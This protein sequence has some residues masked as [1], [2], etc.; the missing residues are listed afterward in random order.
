MREQIEGAD[1]ALTDDLF[2]GSGGGG[3]STV[4]VVQGLDGYPL[5]LLKDYV[6]LAVDIA[7]VFEKRK[8]KANFQTKCVKEVSHFCFVLTSVSS[9]DQINSCIPVTALEE[10]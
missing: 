3:V 5:K 1:Q 7:E 2:G 4:T 6:T 8:S 10:N 9:C